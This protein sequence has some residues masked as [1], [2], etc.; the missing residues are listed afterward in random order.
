MI[1]SNPLR[2]NF[3]TRL[4]E[5]LEKTIDQNVSYYYRNNPDG[6]LE[7]LKHERRWLEKVNAAVH[8]VYYTCILL[9]TLVV[10]AIAKVLASEDVF[11][12]I[13]IPSCLYGLYLLAD[14][15]SILEQ[16]TDMNRIKLQ[17]YKEVIRKRILKEA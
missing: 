10:P 13:S 9:L 1:L 14:A 7:Y 4:K 6:I 11:F 12:V 5:Y 16:A 3:D 2:Q 17:A 15:G 8:R